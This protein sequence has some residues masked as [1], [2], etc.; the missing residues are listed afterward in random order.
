MFGAWDSEMEYLAKLIEQD[1]RNN[2][3]WNQRYYLIPKLKG[4]DVKREAEYE[5]RAARASAIFWCCIMR[6]LI[7][8]PFSSFSFPDM[9]LQKFGGL[10][11]MKARGTI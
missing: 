11:I 9:C 7:R 3:A 4:F 2:S 6:V 10:R 5:F 8:D 1:F